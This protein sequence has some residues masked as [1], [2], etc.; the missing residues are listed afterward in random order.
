MD[1]YF[2]D[3]GW[4]FDPLPV[5]PFVQEDLIYRDP[6]EGGELIRRENYRLLRPRCDGSIKKLRPPP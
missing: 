1:L 6:F 2:V 3:L 4:N 5:C